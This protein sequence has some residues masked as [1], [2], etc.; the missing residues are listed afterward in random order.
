MEPVAKLWW[1]QRPA[2]VTVPALWVGWDRALLD[3][4]DEETYRREILAECLPPKKV[5]KE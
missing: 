3:S 2:G 4:M 1:E 5:D